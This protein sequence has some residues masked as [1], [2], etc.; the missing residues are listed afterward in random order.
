MSNWN[1]S[2]FYYNHSFTDKFDDF[3]LEVLKEIHYL[4]EME[5]GDRDDKESYDLLNKIVDIYE[6]CQ[7][8]QMWDI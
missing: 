2:V 1:H 8:T 4:E 6:E 5:E 3:I 7:R